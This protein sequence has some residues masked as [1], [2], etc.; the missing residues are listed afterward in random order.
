M[1]RQNALN[2]RRRVPYPG[3]GS[4]YYIP[5]LIWDESLQALRWYGSYLS[6][7]LVFWGGVVGGVG[8][9]LVTSLL[10]LNHAPQGGAVR[11]TLEEMRAVL[12]ALQARD[13]KL[14][15]QVHTHPGEAFHSLGD[16]QSPAS[17]HPGYISIVIPHFGQDVRSLTHCSVYEY[18]DEFVA[19]VQ[20]DIVNRFV[21]QEQVVQVLPRR[22]ASPDRRPWNGLNWIQNIIARRRP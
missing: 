15:A 17:F 10:V 5:A 2:Q 12:H 14:V 6:E 3:S 16:S 22:S 1:L 9:I 11:P 8:E 19:L 18:Q 13:E 20:S 4:R 7:G 21:I